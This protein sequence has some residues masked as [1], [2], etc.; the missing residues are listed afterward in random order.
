MFYL[1]LVES[2]DVYSFMSLILSLYS[3]PVSLVKFPE[4]NWF[5]LYKLMNLF[6]T[7]II[8]F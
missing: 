3:F 1:D 4:G 5:R 2:H 6:I 8:Q 7:I